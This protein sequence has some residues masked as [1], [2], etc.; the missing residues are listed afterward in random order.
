MNRTSNRFPQNKYPENKMMYSKQSNDCASLLR[1]TKL[2]LYNDRNE[3]N[4][5]DNK[6]VSKPLTPF[7]LEKF[8]S[9]EQIS[10]M[11]GN[12]LIGLDISHVVKELKITEYCNCDPLPE[13]IADLSSKAIAKYCSIKVID[14]AALRHLDK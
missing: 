14:E 12:E 6:K 1:K 2:N 7:F 8:V 11:N 10:F 4:K 13:N 9:E 5:T 3:I